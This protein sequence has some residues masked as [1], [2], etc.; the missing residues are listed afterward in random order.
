VLIATEGADFIG[1][2]NDPHIAQEVLR[3]VAGTVGLLLTIPVTAAAGVWWIAGRR[4]EPSDP[5]DG[6]TD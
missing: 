1:L 5:G 2:L 3:S 4:K 6:L